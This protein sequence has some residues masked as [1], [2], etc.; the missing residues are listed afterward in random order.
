[1]ATFKQLVKQVKVRKI[2]WANET[3]VF[4]CMQRKIQNRYDAG[5]EMTKE[6]GDAH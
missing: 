5:F 1:M 6:K 3:D 2:V 4:L